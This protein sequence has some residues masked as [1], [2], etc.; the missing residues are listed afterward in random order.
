MIIIPLGV[1][2]NLA[3]KISIG[4]LILSLIKGTHK[5]LYRA[6]AATMIITLILGLLCNI[7]WATQT[8]PMPL[9]KI[10]D[11][12]L[13]GPPPDV[14]KFLGILYAIGAF[15]IC[16]DLLYSLSPLY[17]L[18][19]VRSIGK[20]NKL[21]IQIL[22]GS[23][24]LVTVVAIVSLYYAHAFL[25]LVD[26]TWILVPRYICDMLERN[27]GVIV[28]NAPMIK[29]MWTKHRASNYA[30]EN[31]L[32][33]S[34]YG[35]RSNRGEGTISTMTDA[36]RGPSTWYAKDAVREP[37]TF[38]VEIVGGQSPTPPFMLPL[39]GHTQRGLMIMRSVD[40]TVEGAGEWSSI[41]DYGD[42]VDR[43]QS[44]RPHFS[45]SAMSNSSSGRPAGLSRTQSN[46]S[47][48]STRTGRYSLFPPTPTSA[49]PPDAL[50]PRLM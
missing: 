22:V 6:T 38:G 42:V 46:T 7:L 25:Y 26:M 11:P 37:A 28:A 10:W 35:H 18:R 49:P 50:I 40:I 30:S 39:E 12:T 14:W 15:N 44:S 5:K 1:I 8:A 20:R 16:T 13:P 36:E 27:L 41:S 17:F 21:F 32:S 2:G 45:I 33:K 48:S 34:T 9:S 31:S 47:L 24:L 3:S 29:T 23:G 4:F 19:N 43:R